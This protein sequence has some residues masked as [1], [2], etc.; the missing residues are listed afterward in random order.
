MIARDELDRRDEAAALFGQ[1]IEDDPRLFTAADE[2]EALLADSGD[3]EALTR[4]YT[5]RLE[6]VR[7]EEGRSGERL[8]LWDKLAE[9]CLAQGRREDAVAAFEVALRLDP[10]SL[11]RRQRLAD[12][13]LDADPR[14]AADAIAQHQAVL[15]ADKRRAASYEALRTLYRRTSQPEKARACDQAL[16]LLG[17][18]ADDHLERRSRENQDDRGDR[19]AVE[20]LFAPPRPAAAP[21]PRKPLANEDWVALGGF[22]VDLQLSALFA[23][24]APVFAAERARTRPPQPPG[25]LPTDV[26]P[27]IADVLAQ[28]ATSFGIAHPPTFVDAGQLAPCA[29]MLRA[30]GGM[31]APIL[32]IGRPALDHQLEGAGLAFALARQLAD[33]RSDR[34]ARLLCPRAVDLAQIVELALAHGQDPPSHTG[35]WLATALHAVELD[36]ALAIARRLRERAIDPVRA[37]LAWLAATDRAAD[38]IGLVITGDLAACVRV[39]ERERAADSEV[40]R[41]T[42][43]V[44]ASVTEEVLGVRARLERWPTHPRQ[45][46]T[47]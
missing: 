32:V 23:L 31:L 42:E 8:R 1:A 20:A 29:A 27:A 18:R 7:A 22:D 19:E 35:R 36:Q 2:L 46:R 16:E 37:A 14:H 12:L 10:D 40:D 38:R 44:W 25:E 17:Q 5:L 9:L 30:Q 45:E 34:F 11:A 41:T 33:L 47:P 4:F 24:V 6:H 15:R 26:P 39:L 28:V 13:Y 21:I 43:L 3:R